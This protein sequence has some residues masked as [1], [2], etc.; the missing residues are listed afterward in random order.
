MRARGSGANA[1]RFVGLVSRGATSWLGRRA[2]EGAARSHSGAHWALP[3]AKGDRSAG[4]GAAMRIAP[5]AFLLDPSIDTAEEDWWICRITRSPHEAYVGALA[6]ARRFASS[7]RYAGVCSPTSLDLRDSQVRD[8]I[9]APLS[10]EDVSP[11]QI[12]AHGAVQASSLIRC[13]S[14]VRR[15]HLQRP[16]AEVCRCRRS[17]WRRCTIGSIAG[18]SPERRVRILCVSGGTGRRQSRRKT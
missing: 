15:G 10:L 7:A 13:H 8:R 18:R 17:W 12:V 9:P 11:F 4:N 3:G 16:F 1:E 2:P 6:V 5:L 14:A